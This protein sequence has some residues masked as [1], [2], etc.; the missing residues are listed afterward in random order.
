M[1]FACPDTEIAVARNEERLRSFLAG[2]KI[3]FAQ[4]FWENGRPEVRLNDQAESV[5]DA[6]SP[7]RN[8]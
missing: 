5:P 7:E 3:A 2:N 1:K 6:D 4:A 8:N